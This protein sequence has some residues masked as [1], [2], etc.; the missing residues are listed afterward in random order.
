MDKPSRDTRGMSC[1]QSSPRKRCTS[2][3][4][5][6]RPSPKAADRQHTCSQACR[7]E[8]RRKLAKRRRTREL[9][10]CRTDERERQ[11]ECRARPGASRAL[12]RATLSQREAILRDEIVENWDKMLRVSRATFHRRVGLLLGREGAKLGQPET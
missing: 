10:D 1:R 4:R 12:S 11:R 8:R 9:D 2:C 3:R 6:F 5:W 7:E